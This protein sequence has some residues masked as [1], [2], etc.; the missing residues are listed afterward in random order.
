[1]MVTLH[2]WLRW[3]VLL[4]AVGA[5]GAYAL[6]TVRDRAGRLPR[7]LGAVYASTLGV[8]LL[9][10][11]AV[12]GEQRRWGGGDA[13]LSWIHPALM[14]AAVGVASIGIGRARRS[15]RPMVGLG[16]VVASV[17]IILAAIPTG[18]WPL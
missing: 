3:A 11:L 14:V 13:F 12:W 9:V 2:T 15:D 7:V 16:A 8:Q 18:S 1:M 6:A 4:A 17:A 5:G 10:G